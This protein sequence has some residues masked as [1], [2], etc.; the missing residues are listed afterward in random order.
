MININQIENNVKKLIENINYEIS[1][2]NS[3]ISV[4]VVNDA[5]SQQIV[6]TYQNTEKKFREGEVSKKES[7]KRTAYERSRKKLQAK[8]SGEEKSDE[9]SVASSSR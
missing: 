6:D 3:E 9:K 8:E 4:V 7:D 2:L 1:N 5:S